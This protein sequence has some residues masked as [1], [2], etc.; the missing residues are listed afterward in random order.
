MRGM[1]SMQW[2]STLRPKKD[3]EIIRTK[4]ENVFNRGDQETNESVDAYVA[5]VRKLAKTC[6]NGPSQTHLFVIEW[7]LEL[8]IILLTRNSFRQVN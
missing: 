3:P 2:N 4:M 7:W 8:V 5:A 1:L 6:N